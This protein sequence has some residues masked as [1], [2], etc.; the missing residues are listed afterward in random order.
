MNLF[1]MTKNK[2]ILAQTNIKGI[3]VMTH[4]TEFAHIHLRVPKALS[5]Y[6]KKLA[7]NKEASVTSIIVDAIYAE[8]DRAAKAKK[9]LKE[10][11]KIIK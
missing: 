5:L 1:D 8:K 6:L 7:L 10:S 2:C 4:Q 3:K 9:E 11:L